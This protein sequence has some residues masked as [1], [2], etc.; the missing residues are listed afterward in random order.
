MRGELLILHKIKN[1]ETQVMHFFV[2]Y[3]GFAKSFQENYLCF[4]PA[5]ATILKEF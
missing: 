5:H 2:Y 4:F 3:N 1:A